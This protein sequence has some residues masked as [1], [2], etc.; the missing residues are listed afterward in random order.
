MTREKFWE[1]VESAIKS[2]PD[3]FRKVLDN[4]EVIVQNHP[5]TD[6][7]EKF[8]P[9]GLLLGLY[10]GV[11]LTHRG[12][13]F[14]SGNY[15]F[16]PPDRIFLYQKN[17]ERYCRDSNKSIVSQIKETLFHEIGHYLGLSEEELEELKY[18]HLK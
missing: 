9:G 2:L 4:I 3:E 5:D 15:S 13:G 11:P 8:A 7:Q 6:T 17:I 14:A 18:Q 16:V 1:T 10:N 12:S